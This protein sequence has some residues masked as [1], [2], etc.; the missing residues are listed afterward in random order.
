MSQVLVLWEP[1]VA[2]FIRVGDDSSVILTEFLDKE[3]LHDWIA[4]EVSQTLPEELI[5]VIRW[6]IDRLFV[7]FKEQIM[8]TQMVKKVVR[9]T[10]EGELSIGTQLGKRKHE[11]EL[12]LP[13]I[14]NKLDHTM[15]NRRGT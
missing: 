12:T 15:P 6:I 2:K 13:A 11:K 1:L 9:T 8:A 14:T 7:R 3:T 10:Q 4:A 5:S